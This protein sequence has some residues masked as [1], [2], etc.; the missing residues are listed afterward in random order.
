METDTVFG[1]DSLGFICFIRSLRA[2][3]FPVCIN[4]SLKGFF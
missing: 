3:S 2:S 4:K 1:A